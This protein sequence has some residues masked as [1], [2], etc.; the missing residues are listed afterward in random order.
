M[1]TLLLFVL[2]IYFGLK[3][4][5]LKH[6]IAKSKQT[7]DKFKTIHLDLVTDN[8]TKLK[9][10]KTTEDDLTFEFTTNDGQTIKFPNE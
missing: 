10:N 7:L 9:I 3:C 6:Q 5:A 1:T 4:I 2:I 8:G